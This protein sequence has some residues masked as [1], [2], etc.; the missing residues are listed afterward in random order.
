MSKTRRYTFQYC[1]SE[2]KISDNRIVWQPIII[3]EGSFHKGIGRLVLDLLTLRME[4]LISDVYKHL[5]PPDDPEVT[6]DA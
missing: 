5:S 3:M 6:G 4:D 1:G 2:T